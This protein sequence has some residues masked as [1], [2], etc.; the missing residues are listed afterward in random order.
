MLAWKHTMNP[1][2][3]RF[4]NA[5]ALYYALVDALGQ[6]L[7]PVIA[8]GRDPVLALPTGNTMV[9]FYRIAAEVPEKLHPETWQAFNLD[10]YYPVTPENFEDSF[11]AYMN[12][13]FYSRLKN[14]V[15]SAHF[16]NGATPDLVSEC[17]DYEAKILA[18]GGLDICILGLGVN[19]HIAFNEPGSEFDSRTR[20][21]ELHP[22]TLMANFKG[23]APFTHAMTLG[24]G[25]ILS[26]KKIFVVALG[27]NKANAVKAAIEEYPSRMIP[28]SGLQA[29]PNVTWF[30]DPEASS[31]V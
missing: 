2:I 28:A 5:N 8:S 9:P 25:T 20:P 10:E 23:E 31:L 26:A 14:Q 19:G 15:K 24:I 21:I 16:L 3:W 6:E 22:Q 30:L 27:K 13:H 11:Q 17:A 7:A 1:Q 4:D 12:R 29:H 18:L